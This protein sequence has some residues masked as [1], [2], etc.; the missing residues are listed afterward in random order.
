MLSF[1]FKASEITLKKIPEY[2][3]KEIIEQG[4]SQITINRI[5]SL[6]A[7][8]TYDQIAESPFVEGV[9]Y[10]QIDNNTLILTKKARVFPVVV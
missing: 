3:V 8:F 5:D 6:N 4:Q 7:Q 10:E 9:N 1:T 2:N